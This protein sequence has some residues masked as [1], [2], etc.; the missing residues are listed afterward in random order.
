MRVKYLTMVALAASALAVTSCD[1]LRGVAGRPTSA[2]L[3]ELAENARQREKALAAERDSIERVRAREADSL[4]ARRAVEGC[5]LLMTGLERLGNLPLNPPSSRYS[6]VLGAFSS[7]ENADKLS[8]KVTAAG[9]EVEML[10]YRN[11]TRAVLAACSDDIVSFN[12]VLQKILGES[13]CPPDVWI[14]LN[15]G[16]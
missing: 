16:H 10:P 11:G 4:A 5:G 15:N 6:I 2:E 9:Y 1:F 8:S 12:A 7:P 13:F 3:A 14:L